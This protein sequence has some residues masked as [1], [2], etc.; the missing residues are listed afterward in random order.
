[1]NGRVLSLF[2]LLAGIL[3]I[4]LSIFPQLISPGC[5]RSIVG[6]RVWLANRGRVMFGGSPAR[7]PLVPNPAPGECLPAGAFPSPRSP[8][9]VDA[10]SGLPIW[11]HAELARYGT[12]GGEGASARDLPGCRVLLGVAGFVYDV[13]EKGSTHYAPGAGYCLFAGRDATRSLAL[14]SLAKED[15]EKGG[16]VQDIDA[17]SV[18]DQHTFYAE[19]YGP[20]IG[21]LPPPVPPPAAPAAASE[22]PEV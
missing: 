11:S 21:A 2:I 15:L 22:E 12:C 17:K 3:G 1:M 13:T 6:A 20:P 7:S 4:I 5:P 8:L 19:K 16:W 9:G 14:G 18:R 10:A